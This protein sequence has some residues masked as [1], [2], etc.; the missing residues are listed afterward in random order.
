MIPPAGMRNPLKK[1]PFRYAENLLSP[2]EIYIYKTRRKWF[3]ILGE[4]LLYKK[5]VH[6]NLNNGFH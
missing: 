4:R 3:P 6:V 2:A 5:L 1:I